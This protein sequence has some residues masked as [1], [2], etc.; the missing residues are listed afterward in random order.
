MDVHASASSQ[1]RAIGVC[2]LVT[3]CA[4][5]FGYDS[6]YFSGLLP[7][8]PIEI[9]LLLPSPSLLLMDALLTMDNI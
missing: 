5:Q 8:D 7:C 3:L 1:W 2:V 9:V 4:F 6:S